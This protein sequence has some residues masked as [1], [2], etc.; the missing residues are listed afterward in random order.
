MLILVVQNWIVNR[1]NVSNENVSHKMSTVI[2]TELTKKQKFNDARPS[3]INRNYGQ[4]PYSVERER[5]K[6]C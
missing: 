3:T 4:I 2:A 5:K 6:K 1:L